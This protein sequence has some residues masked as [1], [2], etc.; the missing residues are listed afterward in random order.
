VKRKGKGK[1]KKIKVE[2]GV[3]NVEFME[4]LSGISLEDVVYKK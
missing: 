2:L 3:S 4:V 1:K